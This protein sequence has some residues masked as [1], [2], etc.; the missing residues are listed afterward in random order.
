MHFEVLVEDPV[1]QGIA[2]D[3]ILAE[4]S[5]R[6]LYELHTWKIASHIGE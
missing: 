2:I 6:E 3:R 4:D 1:R 5:W